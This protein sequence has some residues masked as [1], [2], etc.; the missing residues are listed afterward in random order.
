MPSFNSIL[1]QIYSEAELLIS[2]GKL[3]LSQFETFVTQVYD[4]ITGMTCYA[5]GTL[6]RTAQGD[7]P[8]EK[9]QVGDQLVTSTGAVRPIRWL[10]HRTVDCARHEQPRLCW[11]VKIAANAFGQSKPSQDL[12]VS[13]AHA[14]CVSVLDEILVPASSLINGANVSQVEMGSVTYWHIEL[15]SHDVILANNLPA[16]TY[17]DMGNRSFFVESGTVDLAATPDANLRTVEDFCRPFVTDGPAIDAIRARLRDR[18][19]A[20]GWS[21]DETPLGNVHVVADGTLISPETDGLTARF[22]VPADAKDVRII[23]DTT[24]PATIVDS[25]DQRIL[26]ICLKKIAVDDGLSCQRELGLDDASLDRG[27]YDA[28]LSGDVA[29]RWTN[30]HVRLPAT[31]WDGC[32]GHFFL[33]L[34]LASNA[35][36]RWVEPVAPAAV[37]KVPHLA[38]CA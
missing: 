4:E 23:S 37:A 14:I 35:V 10:G 25:A 29:T 31:L 27:F 12:Y 33:R 7:V 15:E 16:E 30:G 5:E 8:V 18:A 38:L 19:L 22:V 21:V 17:I 28:E 1:Q 6:I 26:G 34:E 3:A 2:E 32:R 20:A 24:V 36:P 9:L 13:P 11:P